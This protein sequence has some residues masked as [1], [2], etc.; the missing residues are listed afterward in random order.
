MSRSSPARSATPLLGASGSPAYNRCRRESRYFAPSPTRRSPIQ[1]LPLRKS[2]LCPFSELTW[3][4]RAGKDA[5]RHS[6]TRGSPKRTVAMPANGRVQAGAETP[7]GILT[8]D[9]RGAIQSL[10]PGAARLFG[11]G[12]EELTGRDLTLLLPGLCSDRFEHRLAPFLLP[13]EGPHG[14]RRLEGRRK[15]GGPLSVGIAAGEVRLGDRLLFT[16]LVHDLTPRQAPMPA[17]GDDSDLLDLLMENLPD[18]IYFKDLNSRFLRVNKASPSGS[19]SA[20]PTRWPARLTSTSS[21]RNTPGKPT[22]TN[23]R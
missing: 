7:G 13:V 11:Y 8:V 10:C 21:R 5:S 1:P 12:V 19:A 22:S 20:D 9:E 23:R 16:I 18:S 17:L 14:L 4:L 6:I 2:L 3:R 15:D